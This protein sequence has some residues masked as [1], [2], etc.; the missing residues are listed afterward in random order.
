[1]QLVFQRIA[2]EK[3]KQGL[4]NRILAERSKIGV[5]EETISR[6]TS[7]KLNDTSLANVLDITDSLGLKPYEVFMDETLA[8]EFR[9][10]LELKNKSDET[11]SERIKMLADNENLKEV[12]AGLTNK[13]AILEVK[14]ACQDELLLV[15][16]H[17]TKI[18]TTE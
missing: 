9:A 1:M 13:L 6:I 11:E 17:F 12:N 8:A 4:T 5:S 16:R 15:Y 7:C 3:K 14:L 18:K 10:F 2:E